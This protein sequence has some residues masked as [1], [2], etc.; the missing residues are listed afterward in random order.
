MFGYFMVNAWEVATIVA[1]VAGVVGFFTVMRGASF[2]AHALP[3]GAFAGAAGAGLIGANPLAGLFVFSVGGALL[4]AGLGRRA[5]NDVATALT[6][7]LM[8][9][10]GDLFLTRT[11]EYAPLLYALLFGEVLG[12]SS[13]EIL[14]TA[15]VSAACIAAVIVLYRPLLLSSVVPEVAEAR[16]VRSRYIDLAFLVI[17]ALATAM[18]VPV[19]GSLLIFSLLIGPPAAARA[20]TNRPLIAMGLS[21]LVA[22]LTV[23]IAIAVSY[24]T[25]LPVGFFVGTISAV[26]YAV[27]RAATGLRVSHGRLRLVA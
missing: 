26:A 14:P 9:G 25:D 12:I 6:V 4:L 16:G 10:L 22:L 1:I 8:L 19:V 15:L 13:N 11:G 24:E 23:W 21:V 27:G 20:F 2:A 3:N 18:A 17:L 5:R 7:V